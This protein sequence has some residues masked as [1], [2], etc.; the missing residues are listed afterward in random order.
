MSNCQVIC[1]FKLLFWDL[2]K[3]IGNFAALKKEEKK[4]ENLIKSCELVKF[5]LACQIL[6]EKGSGNLASL[7]KQAWQFKKIVKKLVKL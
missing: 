4:F 5:Y 3:G 7:K 2:G 6:C 1:S